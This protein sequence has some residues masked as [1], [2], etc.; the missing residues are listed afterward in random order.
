M[1]KIKLISG[2]VAALAFIACGGG[3]VRYPDK[4][5]KVDLTGKSV[6][7]VAEDNASGDGT[8]AKAFVAAVGQKVG[9]LK[10]LPSV[11]AT[12]QGISKAYAEFGLKN[13]GAVDPANLKAAANDE[14][15][16][17][18]SKL[19]KFDTIVFVGAEK[20][21][22]MAVP[23]T[24]NIDLYGAV[25][26]IGGKKVTAAVSDSTTVVDT[27]VVAQMPLKARD[28]TSSLLDGS[29]Q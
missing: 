24:I 27:G 23:K 9:S 6:L 10:I 25:Y 3:N 20:G 2:C 28:I 18:A 26:D 1:K 7:V 11:P 12:A 16:K 13:D 14:I 29:G 19:G 22:G 8:A 5:S 15:L 21:T 17:L 4:T